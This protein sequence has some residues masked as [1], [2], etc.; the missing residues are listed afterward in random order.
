MFGQVVGRFFLGPH[1]GITNDGDSNKVTLSELVETYPLWDAAIKELSQSFKCI[2]LFTMFETSD[3]HPDIIAEIKKFHKVIVPFDYLC[4][5]LV[6]RGVH[7]VVSIN[8]YTSDLIRENHRIVPKQ[9]DPEK[10]I[11]LYVGTNDSRKNLVHLANEFVKLPGNHLLICKTNKVDGL[12]LKSPNIKVI[13]NRVTNQ[14]LAALYNMCDYVVTATRGEGVGLPML[15]AN[16]FRKPVIAH[17]QG[18]SADVK[19]IVTV[20]WHVLKTKEIP[21]DYTEVP[22]FLHK[23]FWGTWWDPIDVREVLENIIRK[24]K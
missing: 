18:V 7:Q 5:I 23:V 9:L 15:E 6:K 4:E 14:G 16:Y 21:I 13:T 11:F 3:V 22:E 24:H 10:I 19:K 17:D 12:P 2:Q 1:L 8:F 20:P